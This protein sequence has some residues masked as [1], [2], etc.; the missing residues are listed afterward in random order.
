MLKK[1]IRILNNHFG[2]VILALIVSLIAILNYRSGTWLTGWDN[3]HPEFNFFLNT[4][5][6]IFAA[7]Q[8]YQGLGLLGGMGHA[9]DLPRQLFLWLVSFILPTHFIRYFCHFLM[10]LI[11]VLGIYFLLKKI[12]FVRFDKRQKETASIIGGFFYLFNLA[13]LQ[14]FYVPFEPYSIH[15]AFLPWLFLINL[16][17]LNRGDKKSL[18]FLLLVN[19]LA[20]PQGYVATYFLIYFICLSIVFLF[21]FLLKK[22]VIKK[23][24]VAY[25]VLFCVNAFWLLPNLYF[26]ASDVEV[27]LSAKINQMST[28]NNFLFNKKYGNLASTA[29]LKG[30]WFDNVEID[31][32]GEMNYQM[33]KW[34]TYLQ[35]PLILG[36]GYLLFILSVGGVFLAYKRGIRL[37]LIFAPVFLFAFIVLSTDT[38]VFSVITN[39]FYKIPLFFQIFR[40]PYTKFAIIIAFCLS[41]FYSITFLS[42]ST[43]FKKFVPKMVILTIFI[44]L[45]L[46]FLF[47][48]FQGNLFNS[49]NRTKIPEEYFQVFTFFQNQDKNTRIANFPQ[50]TYWGW[51]FYRWGYHGS[52]FLWYGIEQPIIDRAFDPWSNKNENYYW[53]LSQAI[54]SKNKD[55]FE[56]VLEKYQINWLLL[57]NNMINPSSPK[58]LFTDELEEMFSE[59]EKVTLS[60]EFGEIDIYQINLE[61]PIKNFVFLAENLSQ[62]GP[63]YQWSN[64]DQAFFENNHYLSQENEIFYPFRSLFTG[65]RQEDLEFNLEEHEDFFLFKQELPFFPKNDE[66]I[67]PEQEEKELAQVDPEDLAKIEY[68]DSEVLIE[69]NILIVKVPKVKG[70]YSAAIEPFAQ[71][72]LS[73]PKN[74]HQFSQGQLENKIIKENDQLWLNLSALDANNCSASFWLPNLTHRYAYL[75][76]L[77][78]QYKQGKSL[79]FWLENLTNKRADIETQLPKKEEST[80]F[81]IQ[82]PMSPD[83]LGYSLHFDNIS[84][85]RVSTEN[86]LGRI[87]VNP[88]PYKLLTGIK[89]IKTLPENQK[90]IS[91]QSVEHPNSSL[92]QIKRN[93]NAE[94]ILI[95]SQAYHSGWQAYETKEN[96]PQLLTPLLGNKIDTH[97]LVNNWENGW[98]IENEQE[99][100]IVFL[101]QYLE[102]LG[103]L[104]LFLFSCSTLV[105]LV[106]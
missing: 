51:Y 34:A 92:Y 20:I 5:R 66:L 80:S 83:G 22:R 70:Y 88:I 64:D 6:S 100:A 17:F 14:M 58:A 98:F 50:Y 101:P 78:S 18:V 55:L 45:P 27:N 3:L 30:F 11:G 53:E 4:K 87:T 44:L 39:L 63:E 12:I 96:T 94:Q 54:Y 38:L 62:I 10:L 16:N 37:A 99:I 90:L 43:F 93:S 89:L 29:I 21:Y 48:T 77:K 84:I 2:A 41:I 67:I 7:W 61:T 105:F 106:K 74:C 69:K 103:F 36:I 49:K 19:I 57:D 23:V 76:T 59:S 68:L 97:V 65:R 85:G 40:F 42:L 31:K 26:V 104:I 8:E 82:P 13:T 46:I 25:F 95:L 33:G 72:D 56:K 32:R 79:V 102:Y 28:E 47:P 75:I 35:N 73:S 1:L 71:I 15:F 81:F 91:P 86:N 9:S 24:L 52:G 60:Q